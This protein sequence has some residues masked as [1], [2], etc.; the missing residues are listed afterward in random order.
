MSP[1]LDEHLTHLVEL[2]LAEP[3]PLA[4]LERRVHTR[5]R[6]RQVVGGLVA[7]LVVAAAIPV[8]L[9]IL[10]PDSG[11]RV[12]HT[13]GPT[14]RPAA[15]RFQVRP[16]LA[17]TQPPCL[18]EQL[19]H[20]DMSHSGAQMCFTVGPVALD[21][22]SVATVRVST[23]PQDGIGIDITLTSDGLARFNALA[24]RLVSLPAP[25]NEVAFAVDGRVVSNPRINTGHFDNPQIRVSGSFGTEAFTI[26]GSGACGGVQ[27]TTGLLAPAMPSSS[28]CLVK[29]SAARRELDST[30]SRPR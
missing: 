28:T 13:T 19:P 25:M 2:R 27:Q 4:A 22:T 20:S 23:M 10:R 9:L 15:D 3:E 11:G 5:R 8:G 29:C 7:A 17:V 14:A 1:T 24:Q 12:I 26:S 21:G 16:V 30:A 18:G 6:R